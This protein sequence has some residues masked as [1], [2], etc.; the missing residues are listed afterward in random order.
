M[1]PDRDGAGGERRPNNGFDQIEAFAHPNAV[2]QADGFHVSD[3]ILGALLMLAI[4][5]AAA[6]VIL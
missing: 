6:L 3:F 5:L 1:S 2:Q 4:V